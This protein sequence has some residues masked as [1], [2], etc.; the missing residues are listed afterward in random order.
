MLLLP[1]SLLAFCLPFFFLPDFL[2]RL[3]SNACAHSAS[4]LHGSWLSALQSTTEYSKLDTGGGGCDLADVRVSSVLTEVIIAVRNL[5]IGPDAVM[6]LLN[7]IDV[8]N[9]C[10]EDMPAAKLFCGVE[11]Y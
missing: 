11:D 8:R 7:G 10:R 4:R 9:P 5:R 1:W 6:F 3:M 2:L